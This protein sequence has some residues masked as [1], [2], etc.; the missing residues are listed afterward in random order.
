MTDPYEPG[1]FYPNKMGRIILQ[2]LEEV[3]GRNGLIAVLNLAGQQQYINNYPSNNL[4]LGFGFDA[5]SQMLAA[6]ERLYGPRGGQGLALRTG[7]A[8]FKYGLREFGPLVSVAELS[9]RLLPLELKLRQGA[10]IFMGVFNQYSDQRVRVEETPDKF[11]WHIERCPMCWKRS[12]RQP[13]CQL[14]VGV[15]QEAL[16][17]VSSG[18]FFTVEETACIGK[19]DLVCTIVI[20]K[21]PLD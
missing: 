2:S 17:W 9:Y 19:G 16:Y 13:V 6:L 7:R 10:D 15:L 12:S 20:D 5:L 11:Y 18:K 1:F 21:Q 14:A 3:V 8:C 4:D